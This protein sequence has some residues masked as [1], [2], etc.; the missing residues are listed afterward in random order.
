MDAT[1]FITDRMSDM[2]HHTADARLLGEHATIQPEPRIGHA[3][4]RKKV[5][6]ILVQGSR[7]IEVDRCDAIGWNI[8]PTNS[9]RTQAI[10]RD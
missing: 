9:I 2:R 1:L 6:S 10:A 3:G 5:L 4:S 7:K 8:A